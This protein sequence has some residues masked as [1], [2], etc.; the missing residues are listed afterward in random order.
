MENLA[1]YRCYFLD[2]TG[3]LTADETIECAGEQEAVDMALTMLQR[4]PHHHGIELR[5]GARVVHME[6]R[7]PEIPYFVIRSAHQSR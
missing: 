6:V 5:K 7:I 4:R 3:A 2:A 1:Q